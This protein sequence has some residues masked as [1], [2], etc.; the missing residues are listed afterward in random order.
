MKLT[1]TDEISNEL[2][3]KD[4]DLLLGANDRFISL[5][6]RLSESH[7]QAFF[8]TICVLEKLVESCKLVL[9]LIFVDIFELFY[10]FLE[11]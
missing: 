11:E 2:D 4:K 3:R 6:N 5:C 9:L 1:I 7:L 10:L 8:H